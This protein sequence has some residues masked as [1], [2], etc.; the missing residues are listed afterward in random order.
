M[1]SIYKRE[2]KSYFYSPIIYVL[3][4]VFLLVLSIFFVRDNIYGGQASFGGCFFVMSILMLIILPIL[5]MRTMADERKNG[6]EVL[7]ITSPTSVLQIIVGKF[8]A[9]Y[10]V[11]LIMTALTIPYIIVLFIFG[12]PNLAMIIGGY[13]GYMLLCACY[14]SVGIFFSCLV[15]SQIIAAVVSILTLFLMLVMS[16]VSEIF[17]GAVA[18]V[19]DWIS[20]LSRYNEFSVGFIGLAP[21]VYYISFVALFTFLSVRVI[22]QRRWH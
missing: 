4:G 8:L 19:L 20:I 1:S 6:T 7:L 14:I 18:I 12:S 5:T 21:L 15:E 3:T 13:I 10:T 17:G 11:F 22:E 16:W 9:A 2:M